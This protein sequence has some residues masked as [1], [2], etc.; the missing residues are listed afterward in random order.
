MDFTFTFGEMT[1][2]QIENMTLKFGIHIKNTI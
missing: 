1:F 2:I